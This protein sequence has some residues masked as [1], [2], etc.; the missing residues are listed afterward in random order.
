[1]K[2]ESKKIRAAARGQECAV[3]LVGVCNYNQETTVLAHLPCG[4]RGIGIK[5]PDNIAVFACSACHDVIDGRVKGD[6]DWKDM[7]RALA[8]TQEILIYKGLV[9]IK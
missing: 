6:V 4:R 8:E 2:I 9:V 5:S 1:M 7:L 3:R